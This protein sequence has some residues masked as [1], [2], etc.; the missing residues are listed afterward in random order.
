MS[1]TQ[2]YRV[3]PLRLEHR[4]QWERLYAG[5]AAF[6]K[7][8]QTAEM[9][10]IVWRWIFDAENELEALVALDGDG[11]V[12]GLAHYRPLLRPLRA[13]VGGFLDDLF[14]EPKLR[15]TGVAQALMQGL[16]EKGRAAGWSSIRWL[17]AEDNYRARSFYDQV[18]AR[19][20]FLTYEMKL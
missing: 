12:V 2:V 10:R 18:A 1:G 14:V 7:V 17:T 16:A 20:V 13:T 5:Y 4:S 9:R 11:G 3:V 6:Y 8:E 15:G 19:T